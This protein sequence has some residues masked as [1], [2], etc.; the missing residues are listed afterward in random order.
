MTIEFLGNKD[1]GAKTMKLVRFKESGLKCLG[2]RLYVDVTT[3]EAVL[4]DEKEL[5]KAARPGL[6]RRG[7]PRGRGS[8]RR[9][10]GRASRRPRMLTRRPNRPV[11]AKPMQ[12]V[13]PS[14]QRATAEEAAA[15]AKAAERRVEDAEAEA[16]ERAESATD[17]EPTESPAADG[18]HGG[19]RR[20]RRAPADRRAGRRRDHRIEPQRRRGA[21]PP[22][23]P[24]HRTRRMNP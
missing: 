21:L 8:A 9:C 20:R 18:Q 4:V 22:K 13:R 16:V 10:R 5:E 12:S 3:D 23:R 6:V 15:T 14:K 2:P 19:T 17:G 1:Q 24:I 7:R 11:S